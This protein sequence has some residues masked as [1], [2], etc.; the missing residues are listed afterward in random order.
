MRKIESKGY[1]IFFET[2]DFSTL[3]YKKFEKI[4][5]LVDENT[6]KYC[7]PLLLEKCSL[8]MSAGIFEILNI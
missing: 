5:I 4:A 2:G 1:S 8:L 3:D 6:K 7:L